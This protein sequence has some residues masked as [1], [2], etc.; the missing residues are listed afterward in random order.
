MALVPT[1]GQQVHHEILKVLLF[2]KVTALCLIFDQKRPI[3]LDPI[4]DEKAGPVT[5]IFRPLSR[6]GRKCG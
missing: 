5:K 4:Y 6:M 1:E 3:G 2:R